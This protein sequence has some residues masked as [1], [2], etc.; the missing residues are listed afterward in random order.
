MSRNFWWFLPILLK[1]LSG[2]FLLLK[3]HGI[4]EE[5]RQSCQFIFRLFGEMIRVL[6]LHTLLINTLQS[7]VPFAMRLDDGRQGRLGA[8]FR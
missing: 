8:D 4:L 2:T 3:S 5:C 6:P 1:Q 7:Q